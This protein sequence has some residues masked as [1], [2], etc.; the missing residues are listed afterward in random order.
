MLQISV[1]MITNDGGSGKRGHSDGDGGGGG[2][3]HG[4]GGGTEY[5]VFYSRGP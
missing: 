2:G 1:A 5:R 4:G 3:D